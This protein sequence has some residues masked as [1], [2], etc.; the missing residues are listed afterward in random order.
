MCVSTIH[1]YHCVYVVVWEDELTG[2]TIVAPSYQFPMMHNDVHSNAVSL[3]QISFRIQT[4]AQQTGR[5]VERIERQIREHPKEGENRDTKA[6]KGPST[7]YGLI[8]TN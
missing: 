2:R 8:R 7:V 5:N 6:A 3:L 4:Q 1:K